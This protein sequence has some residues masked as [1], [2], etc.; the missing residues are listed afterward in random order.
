MNG[1]RFYYMRNKQQHGPISREDL[2][3]LCGS[4]QVSA[5]DFVWLGQRR[6]FIGPDGK[7]LAQMPTSMQKADSKE[8]VLIYNV[9]IDSSRKR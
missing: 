2:Q 8:F 3:T 4:G 6:W 5:S 1:P 7:T 9:P